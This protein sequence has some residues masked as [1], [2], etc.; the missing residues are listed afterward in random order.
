[1][2]DKTQRE[3]SRLSPNFPN[4]VAIV[5]LVYGILSIGGFF[6]LWQYS[7]SVRA[8]FAFSQ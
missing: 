6:L 3:T 7:A 1:M 5:T 8:P 2:A 4:F